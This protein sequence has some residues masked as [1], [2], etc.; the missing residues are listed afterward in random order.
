MS[1]KHARA[2]ESRVRCTMVEHRMKMTLKTL[3]NLRM[4]PTT[5]ANNLKSLPKMETTLSKSAPRLQRLAVFE[6]IFESALGKK[7]QREEYKGKD[8]F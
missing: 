4:R 6:G 2:R 1:P 3:W 7:W 8:R 5:K